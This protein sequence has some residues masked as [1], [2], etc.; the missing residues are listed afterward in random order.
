MICCLYWQETCQPL[1]SLSYEA[2][3]SEDHFKARHNVA[4]QPNLER[5]TVTLGSNPV[6]IKL[7]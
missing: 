5:Q 4:P 2:N 1:K 3:M 7:F 6:I